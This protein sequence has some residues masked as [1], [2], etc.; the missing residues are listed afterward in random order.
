LELVHTSL[1]RVLFISTSY[2]KVILR[3]VGSAVAL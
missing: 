1:F 2:L 3:G